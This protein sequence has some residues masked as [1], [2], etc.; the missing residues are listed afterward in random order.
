MSRFR[1][2][3]SCK[4][5]RRRGAGVTRRGHQRNLTGT[6]DD[7]SRTTD[8]VSGELLP[9]R[10]R[11]ECDRVLC[12]EETLVLG[13][14]ACVRSECLRAYKLYMYSFRRLSDVERG[15]RQGVPRSP[16]GPMGPRGYL[17][18]DFAAMSMTCCSHSAEIQRR[19]GSLRG[20]PRGSRLGVQLARVHQSGQV[21]Q[22][23]G[24]I[25]QGEQQGKRYA[26]LGA[27]LQN[28]AEFVQISDVDH[29]PRHE[30]GALSS[31]R[32]CWRMRAHL[33]VGLV[34]TVRR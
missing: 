16:S 22:V 30:K 9:R 29:C 15:Y 14:A 26:A 31:A 25:G 33:R 5:P 13:V 10:P 24:L 2:L 3:S 8:C 12:A 32:A 4:C 28:S 20:K 11:A 21:E 18:S 1:S 7:Y 27:I 34:P 19:V 6:T 23:E 17:H